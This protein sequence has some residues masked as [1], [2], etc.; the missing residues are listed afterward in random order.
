M[1]RLTELD[2]ID[3]KRKRREGALDALE[4]FILDT[5]MKLE[6]QEFIDAGT[7]SERETIS[8]SLSTAADW[9]EDDALSA[10]TA[11]FEKRLK[12]L[13]SAAK[14]L[15]VRVEEHRNRPEA[16]GALEKIIEGSERF[17]KAAENQTAHAAD[18]DD[19]VFTEVEISSLAKVITETQ[20]FSSD[21]MGRGIMDKV[22]MFS[23][24]IHF[25]M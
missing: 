19:K 16:L 10:E 14:A 15:L 18:E 12:E 23:E 3:E 11:D 5:R 2:D 8:T 17:L 4:S 13:R 1:C 7:E 20:V 21:C 24:N 22:Q 25:Q 9:L 6:T